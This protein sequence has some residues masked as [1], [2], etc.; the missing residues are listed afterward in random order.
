MCV[1]L[2]AVFFARVVA[3]AVTVVWP[4]WGT[5]SGLRHRSEASPLNRAHREGHA[6]P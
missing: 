1:L 2:V 6:Q 3:A 5:T 4:G